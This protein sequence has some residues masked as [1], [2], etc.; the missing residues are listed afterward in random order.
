MLFSWGVYNRL[1]FLPLKNTNDSNLWTL[2][3]RSLL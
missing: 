2:T 3:P 1:V